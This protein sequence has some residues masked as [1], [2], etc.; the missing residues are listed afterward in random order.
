MQLVSYGGGTNSAAMLIGLHERGERPDAILFADTGGER[1]EIYQHIE[2]MRHWCR[3][4]G[5]PD[6]VTVSEHKTL[7]ADCLDRR[8]LPGLAYGF[9]SCS[10]HFKIRPQKRWLKQNQISDAVFLVGIDY[11][12][13]H[14]KKYDGT[15]YPLIEWHWRREECISAIDR[16]GLPQPGKIACFFCPASKPAE[17]KA[18]PKELQLRA[19]EMEKN[20]ILS[21]AK[22]LG[23]AWSW[24]DLIASHEAQGDLFS[25]DIPC[26]CMI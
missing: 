24:A 14:R 21:T 9:K 3:S 7:E 1:P 4:V 6:I 5:F 10:E 18:L 16:E 8:A 25:P 26:E 12:E 15:R 19:I 22:G 2:V 13:T 23:R 11:G 20:A 17:I